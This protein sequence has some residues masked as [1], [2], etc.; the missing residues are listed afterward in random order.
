MVRLEVYYYIYVRELISFEKDYFN[1][2]T[3][4]NKDILFT[5]LVN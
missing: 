1:E 3:D 2:V 4:Y 5:V